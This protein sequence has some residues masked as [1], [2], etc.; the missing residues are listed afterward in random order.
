MFVN[1]F[2][3]R[4]LEQLAQNFNHNYSIVVDFLFYVFDR[5]S[6]EEKVKILKTCPLRKDKV[7]EISEPDK[8]DLESVAEEIQIV[9]NPLLEE[10]LV[11]LI[12]E[13]EKLQTLSDGIEFL[14]FIYGLVEKDLLN[15]LII[16]YSIEAISN[17]YYTYLDSEI[18]DK[19]YDKPNPSHVSPYIPDKFTV[20]LNN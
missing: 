6:Y 5:F 20:F 19:E 8:K 16:Q 13:C 11:N 9:I 1:K 4:S 12:L 3:F 2:I 15:D 7:Q 14:L 18:P 17:S 10:R